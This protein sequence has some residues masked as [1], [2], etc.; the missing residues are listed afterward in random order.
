MSKELRRTKKVSAHRGLRDKTAHSKS[1]WQGVKAH[2]GWE[3]TGAP[4]RLKS[5]AEKLSGTTIKVIEEPEGICEEI[6]QAFEAKA[7][8]VKES[9]GKTTGNYLKETRR[10]HEGN[11][12]KFSIGEITEKDVV[13]RLRGMKNKPSFSNNATLHCMIIGK[14]QTN[15][16]DK[17][18]TNYKKAAIMLW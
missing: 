15:Q 3:S 14:R 18:R 10:M 2:L 12:G 1:M 7:K 9:I 16:L 17:K 5:Q 13:K 4:E 6:T 11:I 8:K